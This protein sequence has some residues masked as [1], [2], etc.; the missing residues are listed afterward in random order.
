M[1]TCTEIVLPLV[2]LENPGDLAC[3]SKVFVYHNLC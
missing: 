3:N 1:G 2:V